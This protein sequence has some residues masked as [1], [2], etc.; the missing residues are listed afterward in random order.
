MPDHLR[1]NG[2]H[3]GNKYLDC[4]PGIDKLAFR[5][6]HDVINGPSKMPRWRND[7]RLIGTSLFSSPFGLELQASKSSK[8]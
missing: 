8:E 1:S 5:E 2:A 4:Q 6:E 3:S 7:H